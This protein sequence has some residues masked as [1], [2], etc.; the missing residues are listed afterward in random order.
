[1]P[2]ILAG[3]ADIRKGQDLCRQIPC[4]TMVSLPV[5]A[6]DVNGI[7]L[8]YQE[9]G[10]G[11]PLLMIN[12]FASTMDTWNPP[13]L[14]ELAQNFRVIIFDNRGT[15]YSTA[16]DT[17]FSIPLFA[18]D[19]IAL[20]DSLGIARAHVLGLSMGASIAQELVLAHPERVDRLIL[21]AG[22]CGGNVG[23]PVP[24]GVW[25]RLSD[26]SGELMEIVNRMFS[27]LFPEEWRATHDPLKYCPEVYETTSEENAARQAEAF[28]G[29]R[30][31][32]DR[33]PDIRCPTLVMTGQDDAIILPENSRILAG[34]IPGARLVEVTGAGHGLQ[35]QFPEEF[36]RALLAFLRS[37]KA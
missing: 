4:H 14:E 20:L 11:H 36:S 24:C 1:M 30:G 33:L 37:G 15:G 10:Q 12:G 2:R 26:K 6:A 25:D 19:T 32:H 13:V 29:W 34:R 3:I 16:S 35:Y 5:Q 7:T 27:V 8:A 28:F 23:V 31:S 18:E 21:I 22:T 17:P 9:L